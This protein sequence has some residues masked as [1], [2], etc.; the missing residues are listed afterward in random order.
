MPVSA[1][2]KS[3]AEAEEVTKEY[4][5]KYPKIFPK[6]YI[7]RAGWLFGKGRPTFVEQF[8]KQLLA[9]GEVSAVKDQWRTPTWTKYFAQGLLSLV[10]GQY[11]SGFYHIASEFKPGEAT[12]VQVIEEIRSI[13]GE[14]AKKATIKLTSRAEVFKVPRAPSNV[15]KNTKLPKLP[16]WRDSLKEYLQGNH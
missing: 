3:K 15:L 5:E 4:C 12:T 11:E 1:Y 10:V 14:K 13:L 2:Q 7:V 16:Y 8:S 9:G 6:F